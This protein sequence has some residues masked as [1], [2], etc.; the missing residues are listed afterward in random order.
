MRG[1]EKCSGE[2]I[3]RR[4]GGKYST[5]PVFRTTGDGRG[6][7]MLF[8]FSS[9]SSFRLFFLLI[10]LSHLDR[11]RSSVVPGRRLFR[12]WWGRGCEAM[13]YAVCVH[14]HG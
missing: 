4:G 3:L 8:Y 10:F 9:A 13:L 14:L 12:G 6:F 2:M 5:L 11:I 1:G 7:F